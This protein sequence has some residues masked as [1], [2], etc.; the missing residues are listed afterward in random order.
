MHAL[1]MI[2]RFKCIEKS[3]SAS[4]DRVVPSKT[5]RITMLAQE[6]Q[7]TLSMRVVVTAHDVQQI[8]RL[9][10]EQNLFR[11]IRWYGY[12]TRTA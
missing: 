4:I 10:S 12:S 3:R 1:A 7:F 2:H 9:Q 5:V 8:Y 6:I 11:E